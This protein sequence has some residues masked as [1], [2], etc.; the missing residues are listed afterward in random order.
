MGDDGAG[1]V[2]CGGSV[3]DE[4]A[5]VEALMSPTVGASACVKVKPATPGKWPTIGSGSLDCVH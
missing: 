1:G 2:T 4:V 3:A 5:G